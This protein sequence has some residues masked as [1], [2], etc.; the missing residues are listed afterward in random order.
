[1]LALVVLVLVM[2]V[3]LTRVETSIAGNTRKFS[4]ARQNA[5]F[6]LE[7]AIAQLQA[8]TGRDTR[9]TANAE[10][11]ENVP[12]DAP[13][14]MNRKWTGVWDADFDSTTFGQ[15]LL[16]LVSTG[17][18]HKNLPPAIGPGPADGVE[19]VGSNTVDDSVLGNSIV[20][21]R[22]AIVANHVLGLAGSQTVGYYAYW[23][24][25][26][27]VKAR[28]NL[29]DPFESESLGDPAGLFR[30]QAPQRSGTEFVSGFHSYEDPDQD[31][32][33]P[34]V[35]TP[36]IPLNEE[37]L[38]K[39]ITKQQLSYVGSTPPTLQTIQERFHDIT[40]Y[41]RGVL[42]N[43]VEGGLKLDLTRFLE[44]G[45]AA[46]PPS[47]STRIGEDLPIFRDASTHVTFGLLRQ[48]ALVASGLPDPV[49]VDARPYIPFAPAQSEQPEQSEQL[50]LFPVLVRFSIFFDVSY[51]ASG[52][53]N[54]LRLHFIPIFSI[55]NPYS[56]AIKGSYLI[57]IDFPAEFS[58]DFPDD[59]T[60][61]GPF[62]LASVL[63]GVPFRMVIE[64]FELS[65]GESLMLSA[66]GWSAYDASVALNNLLGNAWVPGSPGPGRAFFFDT[67][68]SF[69]SAS[70]TPEVAIRQNGLPAD[71]VPV[72]S[73]VLGPN[74]DDPDY[75]ADWP[76]DPDLP[77]LQILDSEAEGYEPQNAPAHPI[78]ITTADQDPPPFDIE[79]GWI[80][81]GWHI[82]RANA[83]A[84]VWPYVDHT[85]LPADEWV[86]GLPDGGQVRAYTGYDWQ[87]GTSGPGGQMRNLFF[88]VP[89]GGDRVLSIAQFQH[90]F[91]QDPTN[92]WKPNYL[93][94]LPDDPHTFLWDGGFLSGIASTDVIN[95][96]YQLPCS[97]LRL[98]DP[99]VGVPTMETAA[100]NILVDGAFNVNSTSAEAWKA[101]IASFNQVP[102]AHD[103]GEPEPLDNHH[104]FA[105]FAF[106]M[107]E[108][109]DSTNDSSHS[110]QAWRG[111]R[112]LTSSQ[113]E[114]VAEYLAQHTDDGFPGIKA[115]GTPFLSLGDFV[116]S[117]I[118]QNAIDR[119][120][121]NPVWSDIPDGPDAIDIPGQLTQWDVL[122]ALAPVLTVRS[123]TF[124]I[125]A[126]GESRNPITQEVEGRAWCE[127][128]V[129]RTPEYTNSNSDQ[130]ELD[131]WQIPAQDSDNEKFGRRF[132]IVQFRWL[133]ENDI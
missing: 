88:D 97:L 10:I 29:V 125:R 62:S 113:V 5:L 7:R 3:S 30:H 41:S 68:L 46:I 77:V 36:K 8:E 27:G 12:D 116:D 108:S 61:V 52:A 15:R 118:I 6:G 75:E 26:E 83:S 40:T 98:L 16:W 99:S 117:G 78:K 55:W 71:F 103:G 96:D 32:G 91:A 81:H 60:S 89:S 131:P 86:E 47:H 25:D 58:F 85:S 126:Y 115:A 17:N 74:T 49:I 35:F 70:A 121:I 101:V 123:D 38:K 110:A 82:G 72:V 114:S 128:M 13:D 21:P 95:A 87:D 133:T 104:P 51:F 48:W 34:T 119:V 109:L 28:V 53:Q 93:F 120:N 122:G 33:T 129:Q 19:L 67:P 54:L 59:G 130:P 76:D 106:P 66:A 23:V 111:Y 63:N 1:M 14:P 73:L 22:E 69:T 20:V 90:V 94:D 31:T 112:R 57:E 43:V 39:V 24:G 102:V 50:G 42:S 65:A 37:S 107:A 124:L 18:S 132:E 9:V 44:E 100:A 105:R 11:L 45:D 2:L 64:D 79:S 127:A 92:K 56:V 80:G 4:Q 84:S